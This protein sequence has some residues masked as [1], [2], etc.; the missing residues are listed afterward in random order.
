NPLAPMRNALH[1][2]RL[3]G[4]DGAS[5]APVRDIMERQLNS[6]VRLVDDLLEMSRITSGSLELKHERVELASVFRNAAETSD[7]AIKAGAHRLELALPG[8][9]LW[10]EG[11]PV[12]LAQILANLLNN[13][14]KYTPDRGVISLSARRDNE[15]VS[16]SVRDN[17]IGIA[18]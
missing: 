1:I 7:P 13:A 12:R 14:A 11:D 4:N 18:A 16:I 8:E 3:Q 5:L 9:A 17:G 6:L 10:V 15:W 2:M